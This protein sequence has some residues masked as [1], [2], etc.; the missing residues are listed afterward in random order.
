M[1][2]HFLSQSGFGIGSVLPAVHGGSHGEADGGLVGLLDRLLET[3]SGGGGPE[4]GS[5]WNLFGG[6][7][8]LGSNVHPLIVHFPIAFLIAFLLL[9]VIGLAFRNAAVR[10]VASGMLYLGALSA[11]AAAVAGLIA[12]ESVPHGAAVHE[13]MEWHE[14]AGLTVASLS[15]I[16]ALW[17]AFSRARFSSM[18]QALH[19]FVA[20][21]IVVC[22]VFG[23][24]LG[25]L[26]VYQYGVGVKGLQ[27]AEAIHHH[28]HHGDEPDQRASDGGGEH[29]PLP[30][31]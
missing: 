19:L 28:H 5:S 9:E 6:I 15:V 4:A 7:E 16:L 29:T 21:L 14:R 25:G 24:D 27:Q 1:F 10:Q 11:V 18:A 26:M 2:S 17:R 22:L 30:T 31:P 20:G 12:E 23:A 8:A 13:I 3:L